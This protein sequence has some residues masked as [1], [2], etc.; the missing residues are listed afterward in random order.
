M[1]G[2]AGRDTSDEP[3]KTSPT[4]TH[5]LDCVTGGAGSDEFSPTASPGSPLDSDEALDDLPPELLRLDKSCTSVMHEKDESSSV[6]AAATDRSHAKDL[7]KVCLITYSE[8]ARVS[9]KVCW[10]TYSE[11]ARVS[12][13]VCWITYS[14]VARVSG[15]V[16]WITYSEVARVS[17]KVCLITLHTQR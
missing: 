13:N 12:S 7:S 2:K 9:S 15:K 6:L 3:I 10:I 11:V 4:G 14:E 8:V 1:Q 17:G 16:C 5:E